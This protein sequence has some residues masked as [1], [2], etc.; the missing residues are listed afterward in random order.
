MSTHGPE[1]YTLITNLEFVSIGGV[2]TFTNA[3][4]LCESPGHFQPEVLDRRIR[5]FG[6]D[7]AWPTF[8]LMEVK[9]LE[10]TLVDARSSAVVIGHDGQMRPLCSGAIMQF[11]DGGPEIRL[12]TCAREAPLRFDQF[13]TNPE[14]PDDHVILRVWEVLPRRVAQFWHPNTY[15][16]RLTW[17]PPRR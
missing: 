14:A 1:K 16:P 5:G 4:L 15:M 6:T 9:S 10:Y 7:P 3:L 11:A 17:G 2:R 13:E 8:D 12:V